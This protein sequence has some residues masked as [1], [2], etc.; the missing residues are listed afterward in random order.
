MHKCIGIISNVP[1]CR[2]FGARD[3]QRKIVVEHTFIVLHAPAPQLVFFSPGYMNYPAIR[4]RVSLSRVYPRRAY[5]YIEEEEAEEAAGAAGGSPAAAAGLYYHDER[6]EASLYPRNR[7]RR[8]LVYED[9][10]YAGSSY[11]YGRRGQ[12]CDSR[13]S[14]L[15][16]YEPAAA[17]QRRSG[18]AAAEP[19]RPSIRYGPRVLVRAPASR[20]ARGPEL[21]S[22]D[23]DEAGSGVAGGGG[24]GGG[25]PGAW[26]QSGG[27]LQQQ[28]PPRPRRVV[29]Q[30]LQ[31]DSEEDEEEEDLSLPPQA[32]STPRSYHHHHQPH[33][34]QHQPRDYPSRVDREYE[35]ERGGRVAGGGG[36]GGSQERAGAAAPLRG[37]RR[38]PLAHQDE[39]DYDP[40]QQ[41]PPSSR[42]QLEPSSARGAERGSAAHQASSNIANNQKSRKLYIIISCA[43]DRCVYANRRVIEACKSGVDRITRIRSKISGGSPPP[44]P[45]GFPSA[46]PAP[47]AA[48]V[49]AS[50]SSQDSLQVDKDKRQL[51]KS[52]LS[53]VLM[54]SRPR[55]GLQL[56]GLDRAE[57]ENALSRSVKRYVTSTAPA[58]ARLL[59]ACAPRYVFVSR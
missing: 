55:T 48:A 43:S 22:E 35:L 8:R 42:D 6:D 11:P 49:T 1:R 36:G 23:E 30:L 16:G 54:F 32:L 44:P 3:L 28:A 51:P 4:A 33:H 34:H 20:L 14:Q 13:E 12:A 29:D 2:R 38:H 40:R 9:E 39:Y 41:P 5:M 27:E 7:G 31:L 47:A 37:Y 24:A 53:L 25:G 26:R 10:Y 17:Q 18:T 52:H 59:V 56:C 19:S 15:G 46:A 45:R 50:E 21:Y 57:S 58:A